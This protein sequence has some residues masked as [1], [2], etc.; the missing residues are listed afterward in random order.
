MDAVDKENRDPSQP[1]GATTTVKQEPMQQQQVVLE[2][3]AEYMTMTEA[4]GVAFKN[5]TLGTII[6]QK[7]ISIYGK[8]KN[9]MPLSDQELHWMACGLFSILDLT[10]TDLTMELLDCTKDELEQVSSP[11]VDKRSRK[12]YHLPAL[13]NQTYDIVV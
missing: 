1:T 12:Q 5:S 10:K 3:C 9:D 6:K 8:W 11:L 2:E 7:V 13:V 4:D